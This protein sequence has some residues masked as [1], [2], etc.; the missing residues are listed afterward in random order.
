MWVT[1]A[2]PLGIYETRRRHAFEAHGHGYIYKKLSIQREPEANSRPDMLYEG[3]QKYII[4][5]TI[6][7][8]KERV[9]LYKRLLF[10]DQHDEKR[11]PNNQSKKY[12]M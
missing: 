1:K 7:L 4:R 9:R 8:T 11:S 12:T 2:Y 3:E 5:M 10:D 6:G